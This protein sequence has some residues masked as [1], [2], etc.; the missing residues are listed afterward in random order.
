[1]EPITSSS[2]TSLSP[3]GRVAHETLPANRRALLERGGVERVLG[4]CGGAGP[5]LLVVAGVHGNEPAGILAL[6]RVFARL[7][8]GDETAARKIQSH[9]S[10]RLVGLGGNLAALAEGRRYLHED[11]NRLW[12]HDRLARVRS[13]V[14]VLATEDRELREL[15]RELGAVLDTATGPV[16]T[17]DLHTI[18]GPGPAFTVLD[19]TLRNRTF[20]LELGVPIVLGIE[21]EVTGTL[22]HHL[23]ELGVTGVGFESGQ[24]EAPAAV[25]RAEAAV[26]LAMAAAG[27]LPVNLPEVIAAKKRLA[28]DSAQLPEVVEVRYRHEIAPG[29]RYRTLPGFAGFRKIKKGE[30]L[31][32]DVHGPVRAPKDGRLLMPLYQ[33]QGNDGY[34]LVRSVAPLFLRLSASVR[35]LGLE[36]FLHWLPGVRRHPEVA[37]AFLVDRRW[38]RFGALE[39]FHLL[40]FARRGPRG[41]VVSFARRTFDDAHKPPAPRRPDA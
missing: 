2:S 30:T 13:D 15:D 34:F 36:R 22:M 35:K 1:M 40:G 6:D 14:A 39:L 33:E 20:A 41:R 3:E 10:G 29:D 9:M 26:W 25:D 4:R 27:V 18:S 38:A 11:L 21:E 23:S 32:E 8:P 31:G 16:Y 24:H 5:T 17:L 19:D 7:C 28:R 12:L 37:G